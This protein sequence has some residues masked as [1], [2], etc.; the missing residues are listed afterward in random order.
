MPRK[1]IKTPSKP[2]RGTKTGGNGVI[3]ARYSSHNQKDISIEQQTDLCQALANDSGITIIDTYADRAVSGKSDKRPEFQRMMTD[4]AKGKFQYVIAWKSSRIGRNMLEAMVNECRLQDAGVRIIYCEEDF[5]D[6]AAGRFA[7]RSMMNVNQFYI[8]N[9]A[10]DT[11]R[12][13]NS[14]AENCLANGPA[15]FGYKTDEQLHYVIDS[16]KDDVVREIFERIARGD[17]MVDIYTDLNNRGIKTA[18]GNDWGRSS[19]QT[20]LKNEKYRGVYIFNNIRV[21]GGMPRI[22][23]D[24]L[25]YKVQ[26]VLKTKKNAQGRHR[27]NGDYLLTGKLFCGKC[28]SYMVGMSGTARNGQ[29]HYYYTCRHKKDKGC[30]KKNVQRDYIEL[31]VAEAIKEYI[32]RDD[33]IE[34][35]ADI[36]ENYQKEYIENSDYN[37]LQDRLKDIEGS[38]KNIMNAI[39]KGIF[40]ST[41]NDR[42]LELEAQKRDVLNKS[43]AIKSEC[44]DVPRERVIAWMDSFKNEDIYNK[45]SQMKL[46]N[47]F[48]KAVYLYDDKLK[49]VFSMS[50]TDN[51]IDI[52][53]L[54]DE[55]VEQEAEYSYKLCF[56]SPH[57]KPA[58][59]FYISVCGDFVLSEIVLVRCLFA[60]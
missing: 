56:G 47:S 39:E 48:L 26:E 1:Q 41:T 32:I 34:W 43:A 4:A 33:V 10:E 42:I 37:I 5:D 53:L 8:E 51:E 6:T 49:I 22:V 23:S 24:E 14:N 44:L 52:D 28:G 35:I 9:L 11:I 29:S 25:F 54:N 19:F 45:K 40:N 59:A 3:Y 57:A 13:M 15:P 18:K 55:V 58:N 20:L 31:K 30:T 2:K 60:I 21:E 46:F 16:P 12:G 38:L 17:K 7:K 50:D 36:I 27:V